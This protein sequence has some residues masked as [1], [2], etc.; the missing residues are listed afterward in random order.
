[1]ITGKWMNKCRANLCKT[2]FSYL[3]S[4][5]VFLFMTITASGATYVVNT[6]GRNGDRINN[7]GV[8]SS[9]CSLISAIHAANGVP[10]ND[11]IEFDPAIFGNTPQT[12]FYNDIY[13]IEKSNAGTLTIKGPG[14]NLLTLD[15]GTF[16]IF[17]IV[18]QS[19]VNISGLTLTNSGY[20]FGAIVNQDTTSTLDDIIIKNS[21]ADDGGGCAAIENHAAT[22]FITNS[23][24]TNNVSP[25]IG[26]GV[27]NSSGSGRRGELTITNSII[28]NNSATLFGGGIVNSDNSQLT[29]NNTIITL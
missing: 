3:L 10:S 21:T 18:S 2:E 26:G 23:L 19:N 14:S 6:T 11:T 29:L 7:T 27:C 22:L 5:T 4:I 9:P 16:T 1:M 24:I 12:I 13:P 20:V 17:F 28:S 15:G 8:C 25:H